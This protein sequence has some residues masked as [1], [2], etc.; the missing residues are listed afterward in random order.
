M[1]WG[2]THDFGPA[3]VNGSDPPNVNGFVEDV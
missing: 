2:Y 1:I 3:H